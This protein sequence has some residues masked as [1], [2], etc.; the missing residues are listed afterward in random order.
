MLTSWRMTSRDRVPLSKSR[1]EKLRPPT[2]PIPQ[3][4]IVPG[5]LSESEWIS[6]VSTEEGE[7]GVGDILA[8]MLDQVLEECYKVYLARQCIPFTISQARD[9]ILQIAEWRFLARDEGE[10]TVEEDA[11]W[12]EEEEPVACVT[13]SWAQGSVPVI[14]TSLTLFSQ[15][16]EVSLEKLPEESLSPE[17]T[18]PS[19]GPPAAPASPPAVQPSL[20]RRGQP[21]KPLRAQHPPPQPAP[22][23]TPKSRGAYRPHRGP[24]R[25][26]GL[27][28]TARPLAETG[29]GQ[30][31]PEELPQEDPGSLQQLLPLSCSNLLKIQTGRPPHVQGVMYDE[32]GTVIAMPTL[33]PARLPRRW[34]RPQVEVLDPAVEAKRQEVLSF[35]SGRGQRSAKSHSWA[36]RGE[37]VGTQ[38]LQVVR[39][40]LSGGL[41]QAFCQTAQPLPVMG[42]SLR[43][44]HHVYWKPS[45]LLESIELAPGVAITDSSSVKRGPCHGVLHE[46]G[47]EELV[48]RNLQP[49]RPRA[50]RPAL[51]VQQLLRDHA[52]QVRPATLLTSLTA[53]GPQRS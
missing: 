33:D 1:A 37:A 6:L 38:R 43:S 19:T 32:F 39:P 47:G 9:A 34:I 3:V 8:W 50:T 17:E 18:Q 51:A 48:Q 27:E 22:P 49:I 29:K 23:P 5:R 10:A 31:L 53:P 11:T 35:L 21:A 20:E 44:S 28:S 15:E 24:L 45:N 25:S 42:K 46:E 41:A 12:Q 2:V 14:Q 16:R 4:D 40:T 26:A 52:P 13:D 30:A 36:A 7:D